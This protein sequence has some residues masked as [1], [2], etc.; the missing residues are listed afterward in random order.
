MENAISKS[1]LKELQANAETMT[2]F[3]FRQQGNAMLQACGKIVEKAQKESKTATKEYIDAAKIEIN[4]LKGM[5]ESDEYTSE[6]K[7]LFAERI[8]KLVNS[9]RENKWVKDILLFGSIC[10]FAGLV[11]KAIKDTIVDKK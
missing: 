11:V 7:K 2:D 4:V 5:I 8:A 3:E 6:D 9:F 1:A 10:L